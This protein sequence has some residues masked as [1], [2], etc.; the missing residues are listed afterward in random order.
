MNCPLCGRPMPARIHFTC[1]PCWP[2]IPAP[3]RQ[4]LGRMLRRKQS[5][6]SKLAAV[7]RKMKEAA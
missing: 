1:Q 4:A 2:K 5:T 6:A 7:I 3:D